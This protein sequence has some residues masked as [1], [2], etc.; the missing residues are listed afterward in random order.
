MSRPPRALSAIATIA[1]LAFGLWVPAEHV[2]R[3]AASDHSAVLHRHLEAHALPASGRASVDDHDGGETVED[4]WVVP[5][6]NVPAAQ[7]FD[8]VD[9]IIVSASIMLEPHRPEQR[10]AIHDPPWLLSSSLRAPPTLS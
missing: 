1:A 10:V 6:R 4:V 3:I 8:I 9:R 5:V 2:H 7:V